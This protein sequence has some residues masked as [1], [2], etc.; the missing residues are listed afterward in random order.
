M[1]KD[2]KGVLKEW[3][4]GQ[5]HSGSSSGPV[6][7]SQKQ[8]VA[9]GLSEQRQMRHPHGNLGKYLHPKKSR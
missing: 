7:K 5:L 1:P 8:A 3:K 2:L 9:I 4:S 6:V